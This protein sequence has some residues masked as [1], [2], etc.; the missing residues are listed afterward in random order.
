MFNRLAK[1]SPVAWS[2]MASLVAMLS[3]NVFALSQQLHEA[4]Q[5][6]APA[7]IVQGALA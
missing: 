1:Q 6:A 4:P 3:L 7:V 2:S 5:F